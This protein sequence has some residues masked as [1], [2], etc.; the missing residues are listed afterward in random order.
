MENNYQLS[1]IQNYISGLMNKEEM[2]QLEKEALEDPFLQDAIE[3]YRMQKGVDV[4]QLSLLQQRLNR[5]VEQTKSTRNA[6]F[7]TWQRLAIG[8]AAGVI[9]VVL[10]AFIYFRNFT[11]PS[12]RTTEVELINPENKIAIEPLLTGGDASPIGGWNAFEQYLQKNTQVRNLHG[13]IVVQFSVDK[14]GKLTNFIFDGQPNE[15]LKKE[16]LRLIEQ[17]PKW[18]GN[19]GKLIILFP[20]DEHN[21]SQ[22]IKPPHCFG[23][24]EESK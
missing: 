5:R 13:K 20:A 21:F 2:F 6:Q 14:N 18:Q 8:C 10:I 11:S 23:V 19:Q 9:F 7:Y 17:G 4:R 16:V 1:R 12:S 24:K 22:V 15:T 3:G